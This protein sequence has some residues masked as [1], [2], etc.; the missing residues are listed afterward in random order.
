MEPFPPASM[1]LRLLEIAKLCTDMD[2]RHRDGYIMVKGHEAQEIERTARFLLALQPH[3]EA[4]RKIM[5]DRN[6][7]AA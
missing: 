4:V 2:G 5:V 7:G 1:A 6:R 3:Q